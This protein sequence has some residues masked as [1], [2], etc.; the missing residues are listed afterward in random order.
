MELALNLLRI[1]IVHKN[2]TQAH[3]IM[4]KNFLKKDSKT[5][6]TL[7][8]LS[9]VILIISIL[10]TGGLSV[11]ITALNNAK[12]KVS[13]DRMAEIY[14]ALGN[15]L[16]INNFLPCPASVL[17]VKSSSSLYG[18]AVDNS[19]SNCSASSIGTNGV[20]SSISSGALNLVYGM[21]PVSTL[22]LPS[23][24]AEDGFGNKFAYVLDKR[25]AIKS[26]D[27]GSGYAYKT[28]GSITVKENQGNVDQTILNG[29]GTSETNSGAV[30]A[31]ISYGSNQF[32]A[33]P[34]NSA[35]RNVR[36]TDSYEMDND[37]GSNSPSDA[38]FDTT[39]FSDIKNSD[40]FDDIVFYKNR[41]SIL[42]D[43]NALFLIPCTN[44]TL[45]NLDNHAD[46]TNCTSG[47]CTWPT[48]YYNQIVISN[49]ACSSSYRTTV[50]N[51]TKRCNAFGIWQ[52]GA[53][54]GCTN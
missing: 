20:Y 37:L 48:A 9:I 12:I 21:I 40:S 47:I 35:T 39:F 29:A 50:G 14:K 42:L 28:Y 49:E 1:M 5:G 8:E 45:D 53:I 30:F 27:S 13:R 22:G 46:V 25:F 18:V 15:Y 17:D 24:M 32:G 44:S 11:S 2:F 23:D 16:L 34:A 52:A 51:P 4:K 3:R 41:N 31:I 7:I 19:N 26:G 6:F 54:N 38:A 33:F 43:F 10:I 36:S